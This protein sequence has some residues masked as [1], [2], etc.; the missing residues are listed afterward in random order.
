VLPKDLHLLGLLCSPLQQMPPE[1]LHLL[2]MQMFY[3]PQ[4]HPELHALGTPAKSSA[5]V[6][7]R[8]RIS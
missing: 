1:R 7:R 8:R 4:L 5:N 6:D 3:S 2:P